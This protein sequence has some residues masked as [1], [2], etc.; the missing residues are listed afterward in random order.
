MLS[1]IVASVSESIL[2]QLVGASTARDSWEKLVAAYASGSK[3]LI[4]EL[5][6]QLHTLHRESASIE[7]YVQKA[8]GI[9]NKLAALQHPV[10]ND[11]LVEFVLTR[12]GHIYRQF[13]RSLESR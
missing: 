8:K 5:K 7:S 9:A 6:M 13:I 3:P 10:P 1:W 12:L 4:R 11:D 2:A